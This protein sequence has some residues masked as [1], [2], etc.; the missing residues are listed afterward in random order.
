MLSFGMRLLAQAANFTMRYL[1]GRLYSYI[2]DAVTSLSITSPLHNTHD[3]VNIGDFI[4]I[5]LD[6]KTV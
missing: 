5:S 1:Y 4:S 2:N 6:L 3:G